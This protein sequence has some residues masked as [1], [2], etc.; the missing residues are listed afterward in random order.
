VALLGPGLVT[1]CTGGLGHRSSPSLSGRLGLPA[2]T[3]SVHVQIE[4]GSLKVLSGA[5]PEIRY[6]GCLLMAA[7]TAE[8]LAD[9]ERIPREFSA[10]SDPEHPDI[11][12]VRTPALPQ[13]ID[14]SKAILG[15]ESTLT[16]PAGLEV[17]VTVSGSGHLEAVDRQAPL[18]LDTKR[19]YLTVTRCTGP[20]YLR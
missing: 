14:A 5:E 17:F 20:A 6:D 8:V 12:N 7:G 11:L 3:R 16:L 4:N 9:V 1:G 2:G 18:H 13:R 10:S 19:G 15:F